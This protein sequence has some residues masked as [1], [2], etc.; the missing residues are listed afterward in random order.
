MESVIKWQTGKPKEEGFYILSIATTHT[1]IKEKKRHGKT[2]IRYI[3]T[4][5]T[6]IYVDEYIPN[7][8]WMECS[9]VIAWC[10]LGD[11]EPYKEQNK[12]QNY[13]I[14]DSSK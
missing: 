12:E 7:Y 1:T 10:P 6:T 2:Y 14:L 3:D 9:N 5:C 13:E 8:G 4:P 11:I